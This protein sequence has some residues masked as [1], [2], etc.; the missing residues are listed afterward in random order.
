MAPQIA[1]SSK[2]IA[3]GL[4][5]FALVACGDDGAPTAG[6]TTTSTVEPACGVADGGE[7]TIVA[8][9][10][11]WVPDCLL[12][13]DSVPL[14]IVIDNQDDGVNH[15]LHLDG[16]PGTKLEAGPV[17][18]RLVVGTLLAGTYG[19]VCDIHPNMTGTLEVLAPL[20][21]GPVTTA[22]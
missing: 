12:A 13:P 4:L 17:T 20:A 2:I 15:N 16:E 19:F 9:D 18:Q 3:V 8:K 21:E 10:L 22:R 14:T 11:A 7:V 1:S 6:S 5:L